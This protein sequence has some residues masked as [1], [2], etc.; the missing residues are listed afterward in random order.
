MAN[1]VHRDN[2]IDLASHH[3]VETTLPADGAIATSRPLP[4]E[5]LSRYED[6]R[7]IGEGSMGTVYRARD[8][9]HDRNVA[10]KLLK[11]DDP[12]DT[13]RFMREA[14]AQA[15]V[16]HEN[17]CRV[18][19]VGIA[20]GEPYISMELIEGEPLDIL[21]HRM[22]LEEKVKVIREVAAALHEAHRLGLIHRDIKPG[23]IMVVTTDDGSYKPYVVDFGLARDI[24]STG[25]STQN[26]I[27]GTPAY[28][29][30]E[31]AEGTAALIDRRS[32]V[33]SLGATLYDLIAGR[34]PF[35]GSNALTLLTQV[36]YED[37]PALGRI[38]KGV[39]TQ[40]ETVVMTCLQRDPVRRYESARDLGDDLQRF[41]DGA[42]VHAKRPPITYVLKQKIIRH[43]AIVAVAAAGLSIALGVS[44][45]WIQSAQQAAK[46]A[47]LARE[48]GEDVKYVELFL[49][50]AYG[51]PVHDIE[52]E[53]RVVRQ[54]LVNIGRRMDEVGRLGQGPGQYALGRGHL[55]LNEYEEAQKHLELS[56]ASGYDKPEVHYALGLALSER[57]QAARNDAR[58]IADSIARQAAIRLAETRYQEPALQHLQAS[59]GTEV[60]SRTYIEGLVAFLEKR[61][62]DAAQKAI[63][64]TEEAP[65]LYEAKKLEGDARFAAGVLESETGRRDVGYQYLNSAV[66]A[67]STAAAIATSDA[68]IHEALAEAWI[69]ILKLQTRE[70]I[71]YQHAFDQALVA[72]ENSHK[73]SPSRSGAWAKRSQ[74]YF[75]AGKYEADHGSDPRPLFQKA[76]DAGISAMQLATTD[77]ISADVVGLVFKNLAEYER[78]IGIDP[79]SNL[80][81]AAENSDKA[82]LIEPTFA[83][84]WNDGGLALLYRAA[85]EAETG[86][87]PHKSIEAAV[88]RFHRAQSEDPQY[89]FPL[90]NEVFVLVVQANYELSIGQD[91][92]STVDRAVHVAQIGVQ[93]DAKW[94]ALLTN[95]GWAEFV[96][97]QYEEMN[98]LDPTG[99]LAQ[100][101]ASFQA[102]LD[103]RSDEPDTLF[104]MGAAK[105]L[106]A[107]YQIR[108]HRDPQKYF[109][110]ALKFLGK[111]MQLDGQEPTIRV[112]LAQLYLT[113]A[114]YAQRQQQDTNSILSNAERIAREGVRINA[115]HAPLQSTLAEVLSMR[116][117]EATVNQADREKLISEGFAATDEALKLNPKWARAIAVRGVLYCLQSGLKQGTEIKNDLDLARESLDRAYLINPLLPEHF[118]RCVGRL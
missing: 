39:P 44:G 76:I 63:A 2:V 15:R 22:A 32:D 56:L 38:R 83:W 104:G 79:I 113:M 53:Q 109:D 69:Q 36:M 110:D 29:S 4:A 35:I 81:R 3:A 57:F 98:N 31:Q 26:G 96:R 49:R 112:E 37:A 90:A 75:Y 1:E 100:V 45:L 13:R 41:L 27:V 65:W 106:R 25:T 73:S 108:K 72:C 12:T 6:I 71:P 40:L 114:R 68:V 82:V 23:N 84:A 43:K 116:T 17:V 21:H 94:Y 18:Y 64:A 87:D 70:K 66:S 10:I 46:Q 52:R 91:P 59:G 8:P 47:E 19:E 117:Q 99:S 105:H 55:A 11:S 33:Y 5:L 30:P 89:V 16:Q 28:M 54:R 9:R 24:A 85:F 102:S 111:A 34:P 80:E 115:R 20:D 51:M 92:R 86:I 50:S 77:A 67:Y 61:Y 74:A 14:Q 118:K 60:E 62:E 78:K 101:E 7:P 88:A 95:R 103:I 42:R 97:A 58:R 48:L 107:L 93:V